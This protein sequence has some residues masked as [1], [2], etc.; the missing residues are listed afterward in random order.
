MLAHRPDPRTVGRGKPLIQ[1]V[2][3]YDTLT[4]TTDTP[5]ELIGYGPIPAG[6]AREAAADGV[7]KRLVTDPLSGALLDHDRTVYRPP[8]AV[9]DFVTARDQTCRLPT[10]N[11]RALDGDL[12]H[13]QRAADCGPTCE[14]N[15]H[16]LC[17]HHH[18]LKEH[19]TWQVLAHPDGS[20]TWVTPT[21]YRYV[22]RPYDYRPFTSAPDDPTV[23]DPDTAAEFAARAQLDADA[24]TDQPG[25]IPPAAPRG[26]GPSPACA[27]RSSPPISMTPPHSDRA[28]PQ[29]WPTSDTAPARSP[30]APPPQP[31]RRAGAG[32]RA[33]R[34]LRA[35]QRPC[36]AAGW[37][38]PG[39]HLA[40]ERWREARLVLSR[41]ARCHST[42]AW[43]N[44]SWRARADVLRSPR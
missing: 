7:W 41:T 26:A 4:G 29:P 39:P 3:G 38:A 23:P 33:P 16:G 27:A 8:T 32:R 17:K 35:R 5:A 15:L 19:E 11:R 42:A 2:V 25:D 30:A 31:P 34:P 40:I 1:V 14:R 20:L 28:I 43:L 44:G 6:L 18:T 21:G 9:R 24:D 13:H 10:C 36:A 37:S 22:S 12:D